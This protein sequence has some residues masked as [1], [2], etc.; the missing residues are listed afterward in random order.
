MDNA[1]AEYDKLTGLLNGLD[2]ITTSARSAGNLRDADL[3]IGANAGNVQAMDNLERN[4]TGM[5]R[6]VLSELLTII[7]KFKG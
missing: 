7:E 2:Q 5:R 4:L 6:K 3:S 1:R